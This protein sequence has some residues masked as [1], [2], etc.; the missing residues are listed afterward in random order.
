MK[1]T[2]WPW[3]GSTEEEMGS[4]SAKGDSYGDID[5]VPSA[6][7]DMLSPT[8]YII[9]EVVPD[10]SGF[11][12]KVK[13]D[14]I[15]MTSE[16]ELIIQDMLKKIE[17]GLGSNASVGVSGKIGNSIADA[18]SS[19]GVGVTSLVSTGSSANNS[20]KAFKDIGDIMFYKFSSKLD[21]FIVDLSSKSASESDIALKNLSN[22]ITF[23]SFGVVISSSNNSLDKYLK[24]NNF[25]LVDHHKGAL[26]KYLV[27]NNSVSNLAVARYYNEAGEESASFLCDIA[28]SSEKKR[29]GLQVY[30]RLKKH[31]GLLF[32]YSR[33][34]DVMFHMGSVSYPIDIIFVDK[35]FNIKKISK[36]VPP[37]SAEVFSCA[38]V[39][40]V[41]EVAGGTCDLLGIKSNGK[42]FVTS[43]D[44]YSDSI[45]SLGNLLNDIGVTNAS[46][47]MSN[48][49]N[50]L[51]YKSK[52]RNIIRVGKDRSIDT[53]DVFTKFASIDDSKTISAIDVDGLLGSIGTL[54]LFAAES[55]K[56]NSRIHLGIFNEALNINKDSYIDLPASDFFTKGIYKKLYNKYAYVKGLSLNKSSSDD[57]SFILKKISNSNNLIFASKVDLEK[58]MLEAFLENRAFDLSLN[59]VSISSSVLKV[60]GDYGAEN[61]LKAAHSAYGSTELL[62]PSFRKEGGMPVPDQVKDM[63]RNAL[64]YLTRS[65]DLCQSLKDNF[66]KNLEAYEKI[67]DKKDV[68]VGSKGK[69]NESCKRNSRIAKR[70]LLNI[71]NSITILNK[72]KDISTT[73]EVITA[74]AEAAKAS[75]GTTTDIISLINHLDSDDFMERL[76]ESTEKSD[77]ALE[78]TVLTLNRAKD[79]INANILGILVITQ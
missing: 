22:N 33:P 58:E 79:Y 43:G 50:S 21:R 77:S 65:S 68:I 64:E 10:E 54:R 39:S 60:P 40:N 13:E 24:E 61:I 75:S 76:K 45:K 67:S 20:S 28:D 9:E 23:D 8:K 74:M 49:P 26:N 63:A 31:C 71:K 27:K 3:V 1:K 66:A 19:S 41:L 2:A 46:F 56:K 70:M 69:Y 62:S 14:H 59:K 5:G 38:G 73:S 35:N 6:G 34:T 42:L 37:G 30:A 25:T 53:F 32:P 4:M 48:L 55:P 12:N 11:N 29:D 15:T 17:R 16:E 72:I 36:N 44:V 18:L 7:Y 57:I 52:N 47:K 78:D 51:A